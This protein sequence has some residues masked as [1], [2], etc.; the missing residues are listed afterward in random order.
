MSSTHRRG[1]S[2]LLC[3]LGLALLPATV[4]AH[5]VTG[6]GPGGGPHVRV[7]NSGDLTEIG[8]FFAYDPAFTGGV[9]W[10]PAT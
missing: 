7:W 10:R 2:T 3:L 6:A 9:S 8:G 5:I 4:S 1:A